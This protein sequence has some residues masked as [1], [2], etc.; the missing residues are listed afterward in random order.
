M[1]II[2]AMNWIVS[3]IFF[4]CYF[5]QFLY[6]L[7]PFI[8]KEKPCENV[9][10]HKF[11]VLISARNEA[12]VIAQLIQSI[13]DQSY[14]SNLVDVFVMADNCT[15]NTAD[16]ARAAGAIV[17]ERE[18]KE[19]VGKGYALD[20]LYNKIMENYPPNEYDGFFVFDAD[21]VLDEHYIEEM[22]KTFSQGYRIIT[23]YRNSKNYDS[24]WLSAGYALWFLR[25]S[26]YL[27]NARMLLGTSCAVS[28]TGF[29]FHR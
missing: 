9:T 1:E 19:Q 13:K 7:V 15:D 2:Q 26:K 28:G 22:N 16:I 21:N 23:S 10:L 25:E 4:I 8:K 12:A 11:A 5:Y 29:L 18:N 17:F 3:A 24:N 27:N 20:C 14:P 6:L